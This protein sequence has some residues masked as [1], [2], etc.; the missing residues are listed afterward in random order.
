MTDRSTGHQKLQTEL[1][2]VRI[3][4]QKDL[5]LYAQVQSF[6]ATKLRSVWHLKYC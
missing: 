1:Y 4:Q 6:D 2:L 3:L 5:Q